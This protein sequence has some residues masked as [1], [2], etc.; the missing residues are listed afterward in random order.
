V[1]K[2]LEGLTEL[3]RV[4][5]ERNQLNS[6]GCSGKSLVACLLGECSNHHVQ[7]PIYFD[8][9][10]I[11]LSASSSL[12]PNHKKR[13]FFP[14]DDLSEGTTTASS[15]TSDDEDEDDPL[16]QYVTRY[17]TTKPFGM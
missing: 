11:L 12:E 9:V 14:T 3:E 15:S 4:F 5:Q 13:K 16:E 17:L 6:D 2:M 1:R 7:Q 10:R 8:L